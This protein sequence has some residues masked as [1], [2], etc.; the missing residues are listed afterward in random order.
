M[1]INLTPLET[2]LWNASSPPAPHAPAL[3]GSEQAD[4][5]IVGAGYAGLSAALHLAEAGHRVSVL[6][7]GEPGHGGAGRN[8]GMV[9]PA[10]SRAFPD[11]LRAQFG[12]QAGERFARLVAGSAAFTFELARRHGIDADAVQNGWLQPA[13]S[14]GRARQARERFE[15]WDALGANVAFL[16]AGE[17]AALTGSPI[18][19][20]AWLARDGGHVNPLKLVR[21]LARAA[22]AAGA[23]LHG[24]SPATALRSDESGWHVDTANGAVR[25]RSVILTTD[26]YTDALLPRLRRSV[27]PVRFFQ[28]ATTVLDDA[29]RAGALPGGHA[30]SDTH[31]DLHFARPTVDGRL[32]SGGALVL[33]HDWRRRLERH[34][35]QRLRSLFPALGED[36]RFEYAWDG[37]VG[38]TA[39]F[40]P[41]LHNP[42]PGLFTLGGFNGRGVALAVA[43]G[44]VLVQAVEGRPAAELDLPVTPL[45]PLPLHGLL[46]RIAPL[47][48]L[49]YRW[50]DAREVRIAQSAPARPPEGGAPPPPGRA[51]HRDGRAVQ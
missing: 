5:A 36:L 41:R 4:V 13:H 19:H 46:H 44:P 43:S 18:Y 3:E 25:A 14:P 26:A 28:L 30:L 15:Q 31:G 45:R 8:N 38:M 47:E 24:Q 50:R 6:E 12:D 39:D 42:E 11:D 17:T 51:S 37:L 22:Q 23:R 20:G 33:T 1:A 40:L 29:Q 48:L 2:T 9:I 10:L 35:R 16:N 27:V 32:V 7:A 21:G 34:V 49:R